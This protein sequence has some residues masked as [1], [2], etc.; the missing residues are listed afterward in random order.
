M[1]LARVSKA[2]KEHHSVSF[3][4]A[5]PSWLCESSTDSLKNLSGYCRKPAGFRSFTQ[6]SKTFYFLFQSISPLKSPGD[7]FIDESPN[8]RTC[9]PRLL[10][11]PQSVTEA[12]SQHVEW[13]RE[14]QR[15]A[16]PNTTPDVLRRWG[17]TQPPTIKWWIWASQPL[18]NK[19]DRIKE[20]KK[21]SFNVLGVRIAAILIL[22]TL[23]CSSIYCTC[24]DRLI[25]KVLAA[26]WQG[27][28][29]VHATTQ[30]E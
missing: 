19:H 24:Q 20:S 30:T 26:Y 25:L 27:G 12:D 8:K 18:M 9:P 11:L 6:L 17:Q 16:L 22:S 4:A 29:K 14:E 1:A 10:R 23:K 13:W 5:C 15:P 28:P 2:L 21:Q 7:D 3:N